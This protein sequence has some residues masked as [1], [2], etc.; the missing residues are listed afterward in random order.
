MIHCNLDQSR[1]GLN[2][3][4]FCNIPS[5]QRH[6]TNPLSLGNDCHS[7]DTK[8]LQLIS[9][10]LHSNINTNVHCA[11]IILVYAKSNIWVVIFICNFVYSFGNFLLSSRVSVTKIT[12]ELE[13]HNQFTDYSLFP[14]QVSHANTW[15]R[16]RTYL[17]WAN[18]MFPAQQSSKHMK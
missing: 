13:C 17:A 5:L 3:R 11:C 8:S 10:S 6:K 16:N 15:T 9:V 18:I 2:G 4:E 12:G 7:I 14:V 1:L